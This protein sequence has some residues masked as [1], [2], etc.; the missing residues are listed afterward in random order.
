[1]E[2]RCSMQPS[3]PTSPPSRGPSWTENEALDLWKYFGGVGAADKNTM[4][5]VETLLLGISTALIGYAATHLMSFNP[6]A[7]SQPFQGFSVALL[8]V[9]VSGASVFVALLYAG[10]SNWNWAQADAIARNLANSDSKWAKLLPENADAVRKEWRKSDGKP[11]PLCTAALALGRPCY[12]TRRIAPIFTLY[13]C[14]AIAATIIHVLIL[15][16]SV[17]R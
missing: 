6:L 11:S 4:V 1:M 8:G 14:M 2:R 9:A 5:T 3:N 17:V 13:V 10:Y 7:V 15:I 12:P 16:L